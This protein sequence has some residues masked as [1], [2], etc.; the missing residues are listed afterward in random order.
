M[1]RLK[2]RTKKTRKFWIG[3][4]G[5]SVLIATLGSTGAVLASANSSPPASPESLYPNKPW[6]AVNT[7]GIFSGSASNRGSAPS[8]TG[9]SD[10]TPISPNIPS[11]PV[12][13]PNPDN[14]QILAANESS[15]STMPFPAGTLNP[16][17]TYQVTSGNLYL[18][19]YAG[20]SG[21]NPQDGDLIVW[22]N[23]PTGHGANSALN[24]S[25][26]IP[27]SGA[28]TIT[29]VSSTEVTLVDSTGQSHLFSL[30]SDSFHS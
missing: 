30:S 18:N 11:G 24:G 7:P 14:G 4:A 6:D 27:G 5:V 22:W 29:S 12:N 26:T 21:A 13:P 3:F 10:S 2:I 28:L 15:Q 9:S 16:T 8:S 17:S 1:N 20:S 23:D 25:F 19:L